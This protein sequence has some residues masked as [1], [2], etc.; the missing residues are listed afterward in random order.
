LDA[1][2]SFSLSG[3]FTAA[4]IEACIRAAL[5]AEHPA[6]Q[7]LRPHG[8]RPEPKVDSLVIVEVI[9]AIEETWDQPAEKK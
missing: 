8:Q 6:Q 3:A 2:H 5:D 9:C 4:E 7:V 1:H